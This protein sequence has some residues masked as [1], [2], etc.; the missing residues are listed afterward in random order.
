MPDP[1]TPGAQGHDHHDA[2]SGAQAS[3]P[4]HAW[5]FLGLLFFLPVSLAMLVWWLFQK[6]KG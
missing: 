4:R 3:E 2:K 6:R 5:N 1:A